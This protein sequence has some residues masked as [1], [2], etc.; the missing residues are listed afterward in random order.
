MYIYYIHFVVIEGRIFARAGHPIADD[1]A[2]LV[3]LFGTLFEKC[4]WYIL[5]LLFVCLFI[6][7]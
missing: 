4:E 1:S 6:L 3:E 7:F 2:E 5:L